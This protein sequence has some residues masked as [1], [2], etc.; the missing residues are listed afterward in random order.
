LVSDS[1]ESATDL[2]YYTRHQK[3][4]GAMELNTKLFIEELMWEDRNEIHSLRTEMRDSF[5]T[6]EVSINNHVSELTTVAQQRKERVV[7]LETVTA[8][9]NKVFTT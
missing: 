5:T 2:E 6:Q 7:V 4:H 8:D 9:A 1:T 3:F